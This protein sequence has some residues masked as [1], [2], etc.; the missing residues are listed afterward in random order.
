MFKIGPLTLVVAVP[1]L[2]IVVLERSK[3]SAES[4][5]VCAPVALVLDDDRAPTSPVNEAV[6]DDEVKLPENTPPEVIT[7][8]AVD[9]PRPVP[10]VKAPVVNKKFVPV[11]FPAVAAISPPDKVRSPSVTTKSPAVIPK[12]V[13]P[14]ALPAIVTAPVPRKL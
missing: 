1:L 14:S 2:V 7:F 9:T 3:I 6:A 10:V 11:A 12:A 5:N 13:V 8:E 4:V